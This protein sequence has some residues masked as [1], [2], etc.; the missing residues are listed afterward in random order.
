MSNLRDVD[1]FICF[2]REVFV[3][4][5]FPLISVERQKTLSRPKNV[6]RSIVIYTLR[7]GEGW[8]IPEDTN[9]KVKE[10]GLIWDEEWCI[11][12]GA[13]GVLKVEDYPALRHLKPSLHLQDGCHKVSVDAEIAGSSSVTVFLWEN[14]PA[15]EDKTQ[16]V[17]RRRAQSRI[18]QLQ[19]QLS[20]HPFLS[21]QVL[22]HDIQTTQGPLP[23]DGA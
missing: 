10:A 19:W 22:W 17:S 15:S 3:K 18:Y 4:N 6:A 13:S 8:R 1:H 16:S 2:V 21:F 5:I 7:G 12:S 23:A 9:W 20:S 11:A 14:P